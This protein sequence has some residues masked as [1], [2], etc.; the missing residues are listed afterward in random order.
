MSKP[1]SKIYFGKNGIGKS[2]ELKK[3]QEQYKSTSFFIDCTKNYSPDDEIFK[4]T[5]TSLTYKL[6]EFIDAILGKEEI[7]ISNDK[8]SGVVDTIKNDLALNEIDKI[9]AHINELDANTFLSINN[10]IK[11]NPIVG[12]LMPKDNNLITTKDF[13]INFQSLNINEKTMTKLAKHGSGTRFYFAI[14]LVSKIL[15]KL[16]NIDKSYSIIIDE[17]ERFLHPAL[18]R[19]IAYHLKEINKK[20]NVFVATHSPHFINYFY[21]KDKTELYTKVHND[22]KGEFKKINF[23]VKE[24]RIFKRRLD[25][26]ESLFADKII[27][28]EGNN[29]EKLLEYI[30]FDKFP[31]KNVAVVYG[32]TGKDKIPQ[33]YNMYINKYSDIFQ[34]ENIFIVYDCDEDKIQKNSNHITW[35][36]EISKLGHN[37]NL[38][39]SFSDDL[40]KDLNITK[41]ENFD[42]Y[43]NK[44]FEN[45]DKFKELVEKLDAFFQK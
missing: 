44:D 9:D 37:E 43:E 20:V 22:H 10:E 16:D 36:E 38:I 34:K 39:H 7:K 32:S 1:I 21:Q 40:E 11:E 45:T 15:V 31:E 18:I 6:Q 41:K 30:L 26:V 28:C 35:N 13:R 27:I 24:N 2:K 33:I 23:N 3:I 17:P 5:K 25:S 4:N 19:S 29:D 42:P 14:I 8:I 12:N